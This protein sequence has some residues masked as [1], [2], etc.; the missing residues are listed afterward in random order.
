[1]EFCYFYN[2]RLLNVNMEW[3]VF[4]L[5]WIHTINTKRQKPNCSVQI[6]IRGALNDGMIHSHLLAR[7]IN[8]MYWDI[9]MSTIVTA[10]SFCKYSTII[11][12]WELFVRSYNS[13]YVERLAIK[14]MILWN[15]INGTHSNIFEFFSFALLNFTRSLIRNANHQPLT[16]YEHL[17]FKIE[18]LKHFISIRAPN[19]HSVAF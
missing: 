2:Y 6:V 18:S 15:S 12:N 1:M 11:A 10:I 8:T 14:R 19:C 9:D 4:T 7:I 3:Y 16:K 17:Q 5:V 13:Q